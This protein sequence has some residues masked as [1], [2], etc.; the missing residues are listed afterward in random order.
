MTYQ[1]PEADA[2]AHRG[3]RH[4]LRNGVAPVGPN[5]V[6]TLHLADDALRELVS[7]EETRRSRVGIG[8][9]AFPG[10]FTLI[11]ASVHQVVEVDVRLVPRIDEVVL[12][13]VCVQKV[14]NLRNCVDITF[15]AQEIVSI[16]NVGRR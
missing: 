12:C 13:N 1:Q 16:I 10:G 5:L 4:S 15:T 14:A 9:F 7:L 6:P 3:N 11:Y 2:W 8:S